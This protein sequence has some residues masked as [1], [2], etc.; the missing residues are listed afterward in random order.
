MHELDVIW[1]IVLVD[2]FECFQID[3]NIFL[4]YDPVC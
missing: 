3:I 4:K 2:N 1:Q